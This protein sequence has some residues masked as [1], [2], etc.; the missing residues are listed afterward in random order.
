MPRSGK[1]RRVLSNDDAWI[2]GF[3]EHPLTP[4]EMWDKMIGP[5]EGSP[6]DGFLWSIG[7]HDVY[8]FETNIGERFGQSYDEL[9]EPRQRDKAA[10]LS[11]LIENHGGP[12]TVIS[13]LCRKAGMDF[14]PSVRMNEH[15][16]MDVASPGYSRLRRERPELLIGRVGEDLAAGTLDWGIRTGLNYAF[17]EV[18]S[19]MSSIIIEL[20]ER[21]DVDGIELDFMR[22]PAFFRVEEAYSKRYLMTDLVR[23]VR[24]RMDEL[25]AER[26]RPLDLIVRVPP[27]LADSARIGLDAETWIKEGLV[28]ILVA[29][30][31]F[32]PFEMPI[33]GFVET[34]KGT[35][36]LVYGCLE[37]LRPAVDELTL[38]AIAA[39]Y[40]DAGV[41]VLYLFNFYS[42]SS[43]WKRDVLGRLTDRGTLAGLDKRYEMDKSGRFKPTSQL[44]FSFRNAIPLTQIPVG[45]ETTLSG[46][47]AVLRMDIADDVEGAKA[48][49]VS[50][51][52]TLGLLFEN[53]GA[54]DEIEVNL[55]G[56]PLVWADGEKSSGG[57]SRVAYED[58]WNI[59]PSRTK[60]D[61]E[62]GASVEF[63]VG[64]PPLKHGANEIEVRLVERDN[65][66][67]EELVLK[68]VRVWVSYG[69]TA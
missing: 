37:A 14:F 10:N 53:L 66:H 64:A 26:G 32:I 11:Y 44:G 63:E 67:D 36:C 30:G 35:G 57:W 47:G 51:R 7:G 33:G 19:Y 8:D 2:L 5:H 17:P 49:G 27:T 54:D 25:G 61:T 58:G 1:T 43:D 62:P 65:G 18:R 50:A 34:A 69:H 9:D 15:Y 6:I 28:D 22:H 55:N 39:R 41:D 59:Y 23:Y 29:G 20:L 13:E 68:D 12:V 40:W 16:D 46:R 4:E 3:S 24:Q 48:S 56:T 52:C 21:F 45:L 42:M 38:R 60:V 31:G